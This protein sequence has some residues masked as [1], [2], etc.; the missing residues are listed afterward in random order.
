MVRAGYPPLREGGDFEYLALDL[1]S[2]EVRL[3]ARTEF[4]SWVEL[5]TA[6]LDA[7]DLVRRIE[8]L[9]EMAERRAGAPGPVALWLPPEQV[10]FREYRM[11]RLARPR[12]EALRR[13]AA[14]GIGGELSVAVTRGV[15]GGPVSVLAVPVRTVQD[16]R[17]Y[18][19]R[20]GF[21]PGRVSTRVEAARFG[22][23]GP[24]FELPGRPAQPA[25]R[26]AIGTAAAATVAIAVGLGA[27]GAWQSAGEGAAD[28]AAREPARAAAVDERPREI[29]Q[30][31]FLPLDYR[32]T[33]LL[34]PSPLG[35]PVAA[36]GLEP[37]LGGAPE[38]RLP[39]TG[40]SVR[41][42]GGVAPPAYA[43]PG[44]L[45]LSAE[46][47]GR[48]DLSQLLEGIDRIRE[49][50]ARLASIDAASGLAA[51]SEE[52]A[53][54]FSD[55]AVP[56]GGTAEADPP[57]VPEEV[58]LAAS[59]AA[60]DMVP[61]PPPRPG[62]AET[63]ASETGTRGTGTLLAVIRAPRPAARPPAKKLD[64]PSAHRMIAD[65]APARVRK[66]AS[67][68]GLA[69]DST[70]LIGMMEDR[71]EREALIRTANGSYLRVGTG[72]SV[73]GW[74]VT[75]VTREAITLSKGGQ[76]RTLHLTAR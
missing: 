41:A 52:T 13:L 51:M 47:T 67:Q 14:E 69:L 35:G 56:T 53:D 5:G 73:E 33:R 9:R 44:R 38:F 39:A 6:P 15:P 54:A 66:A 36:A 8:E 28:A 34:G 2:A 32:H 23:Y 62:T 49:E 45:G 22:L 21:V 16:A 31:S 37:R 70:S 30:A 57:D 64:R 18:V 74:R 4:G 60:P 71:S 11:G 72:D 58:V 7:A 68:R 27:W 19:A 63:G 59:G 3:L 65:T 12:A 25:P 46:A 20:W 26:A 76:R 61:A 50:G 75:A 48:P 1:S 42:G 55:P 17:A 10:T 43:R 24:V 29:L 40:A